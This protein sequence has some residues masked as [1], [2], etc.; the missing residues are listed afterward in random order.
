MIFEQTRYWTFALDPLRVGVGQQRVDRIDLPVAREQGTG[1]PVVPGTSL[2]GIFR[3]YSALAA[4]ERDCAG[5]GGPDGS[6]HCCKCAVCAA[7]GWAHPVNGSRQGSWQV[8]T[9]HI[10]LFPIATRLGPVWITSAQ[11]LHF[12]GLSTETSCPDADQILL[13]GTMKNQ[14][15]NAQ[16]ANNE[17]LALGWLQLACRRQVLLW[18]AWQFPNIITHDGKEATT[19]LAKL[20]FTQEI[21]RVGLVPHPLFIQLVNDN[22]ETRTL[23]S[24]D[25]K[26]GAAEDGALFT[27]EAIPRGTLLWFDTVLSESNMENITTDQV[28]TAVANGIALVEYLGLGGM[29]TRGMG[30]AK[31][32]K[33]EDATTGNQ[34]G[35]A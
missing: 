29:N 20:P 18:R 17:Q 12:A 15:A 1:L 30:R 16:A 10:L 4:G 24:I 9:A 13:D 19:Q 23:V 35:G 28:R 5:K 33:A 6:K 11:Q 31:I 34:G 27:Y 7:F 26:T 25:P 8:F 14:G 21:S 2:N 3:A 32:R 22:L